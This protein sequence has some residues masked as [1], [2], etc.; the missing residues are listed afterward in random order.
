MTNVDNFD[1]SSPNFSRRI[2]T[3]PII[4]FNFEPGLNLDKPNKSIFYGQKILSSKSNPR[5]WVKLGLPQKRVFRLALK[6]QKLSLECGNVIKPRL[7]KIVHMLLN[8]NH[9]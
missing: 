2:T 8:F 4:V 6:D 3:N 5:W 9:G 1:P 7:T